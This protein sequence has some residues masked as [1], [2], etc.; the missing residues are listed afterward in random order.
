[1][2]TCELADLGA[3]NSPQVLRKHNTW[4]KPRHH[5]SVP[6][7]IVLKSFLWAESNLDRLT[8]LF[9]F[10]KRIPHDWYFF[11]SVHAYRKQDSAAWGSSI[12]L[13]NVFVWVV[14]RE[15]DVEEIVRRDHL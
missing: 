15:M 5:L 11:Y 14:V 12:C 9:K 8:L 3:G 1:V 13:C 2:Q 7:L 4:W 10:S 6:V